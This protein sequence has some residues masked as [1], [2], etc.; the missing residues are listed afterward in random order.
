MTLNERLFALG[1]TEAFDRA[2]ATGDKDT[3]VRL[4]TEARV[5][6]PSIRKLVG[7]L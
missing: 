7:G 4:L 1:T 3:I 5:D 6:S 2:R